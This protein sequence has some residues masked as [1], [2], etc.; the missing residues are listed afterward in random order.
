MAI[1]LDRLLQRVQAEIRAVHLVWRKALVLLVDIP[2]LESGRLFQ[3]HADNLLGE[4]AGYRYGGAAA[5]GPELRVGYPIIGD[6]DTEGQEVP[7]DGIA[8]LP[9]AIRVRD[10]ADVP[11]VPEM[12]YDPLAKNL[13]CSS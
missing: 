10:I 5:E 8:D 4:D 9:Y 11:G 7:A 1:I 12:L 6:L 3:W 2:Q 13:N